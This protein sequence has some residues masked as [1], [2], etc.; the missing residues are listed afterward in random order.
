[1]DKNIFEVGLPIAIET[2][3]KSYITTQLIGWKQDACLIMGNVQPPGNKGRL[4]VN[5]HCKMRFLKDGVAYGFQT[6]ILAIIFHPLPIMFCKF[7]KAIEQCTIRKSSRIKVNLPAK[8]VDAD[9]NFV[10]EATI[11]D[12]SEGGCGLTLPAREGREPDCENSYKIIFNAMEN[13]MQLSC[14]I[15][16][17]RTV[18]DK[19]ELGIEFINISHTDKE[20]FKLF[21]DVCASVVT[22][23]MDFILSKIKKTETILG[24]QLNKVS[25]IDMLQIFEQLKK[26]G[27]VHITAGKQIGSI[28]IKDG[29]IMDASLDNIYGEDALADL[30]SLKEGEFKISSAEVPQ[31]NIN[32]P[33]NV[34]LMDTCRLIDERD[35]LKEYFPGNKDSFSIQE[36][37]DMDDPEI[38]TVVNA[39]QS[40]VSSLP[41]I[42]EATGLS[43]IRSGLIMAR[44][45]KEGYL[46]KTT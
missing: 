24:G 30:L 21:L 43:L 3:Y 18:Q 38:Q 14:I 13:D 33:I 25:M 2:Y 31:G 37:P 28:A 29:R 41:E 36:T 15:R 22:S 8:F 6:K 11:T 16:K 17:L 34:I 35:S 19:H 26:E 32:R 46:V 5:D 9:G 4:K 23:K 45:M 42:N 12:L 7:P 27:I 40:G 44:L 39:L 1:M 10:A 20:K